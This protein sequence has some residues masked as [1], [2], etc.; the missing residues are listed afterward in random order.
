M[1]SKGDF[2]KIE[3]SEINENISITRQEIN[4]N[5][6]TLRKLNYKDHTN[7]F[8]LILPLAGDINL[9]PGP[10]QISESW[11]VLKK[12]EGFILFI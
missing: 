6:L 4:F 11:S 5:L 3:S 10:I 2:F 9:N 1:Y 7:F 12:N 8:R